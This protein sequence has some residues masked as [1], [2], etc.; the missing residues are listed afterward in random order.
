MLSRV[1]IGVVGAALLFAGSDRFA[2]AQMGTSPYNVDSNVVQASSLNPSMVGT[3]FLVDTNPPDGI[4]ESVSVNVLEFIPNPFGFPTILHHKMTVELPPSTGGV[5]INCLV[6]AAPACRLMLVNGTP[7]ADI[8][9]GS[10][11]QSG[12]PNGLLAPGVGLLICTGAGADIVQGTASGDVVFSG[13]GADTIVANGGN[14]TI[15]PGPG[16]DFADGGAGDDAFQ[17]LDGTADVALGGAGKD[18][19]SGRDPS[20]TFLP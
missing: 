7:S 15:E 16:S 17:L 13:D 1:A 20:D 2:T 4:P 8:V 9:N 6:G 12:A 14:D 10:A 3:V 11:F 18:N 19:A 5:S